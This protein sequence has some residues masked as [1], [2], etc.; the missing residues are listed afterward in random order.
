M[1]MDTLAR[2]KDV[3]GEERAPAHPVPSTKRRNMVLASLSSRHLVAAARRQFLLTRVFA[4]LKEPQHWH[5]PPNAMAVHTK[6]RRQAAVVWHASALPIVMRVLRTS[7]EHACVVDEQMVAVAVVDDD[8]RAAT[9]MS[10]AER[11]RHRRCR[12]RGRQD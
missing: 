10:I 5:S 8:W 2:F 3:I 6:P 1:F 12:Q 7:L 4:I 9:V 11:Q